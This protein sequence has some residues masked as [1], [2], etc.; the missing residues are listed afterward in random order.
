[1]VDVNATSA[2]VTIGRRDDLMRHEIPVRDLTWVCGAVDAERD[3]G[4]QVRA[5]G[6]VARGRIVAPD[7]VVLHEPQ[8]RVAPGQVVAFYDHD[9]L[10][11]GGIAA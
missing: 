1:V 11:G 8:P 2:T 4:V 5:H 6:R 3:V 10:V 7:R 9:A